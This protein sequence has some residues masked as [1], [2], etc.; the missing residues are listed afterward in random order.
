[1]HWISG[2]QWYNWII[3]TQCYNWIIEA[4][5][6]DC[7]IS[8]GAGLS[9][10]IWIFFGQMMQPTESTK[11]RTDLRTWGS[12]SFVPIT[13]PASNVLFVLRR[14]LSSSSQDFL[15][16]GTKITEET[17]PHSYR[18]GLSTTLS[19]ISHI[20]VENRL[21]QLFST[22][23]QWICARQWD[24]QRFFKF[25]SKPFIH[26]SCDH[27]ENMLFLLSTLSPTLSASCKTFFLF[28]SFH[29]LH[30]QPSSIQQGTGN[31]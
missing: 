22:K 28:R 13:I 19:Y 23:R 31:R 20:D 26:G 12:K 11:M 4:Q 15:L 24:I 5:C 10:I 3:E 2:S 18:C 21:I 29:S 8:E 27:I 7:Y 14:G 9:H 17:R 6:S 1:M 30:V 25:R 16:S